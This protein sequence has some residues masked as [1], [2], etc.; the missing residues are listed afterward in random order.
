[1][2]TVL[3]VDD[4]SAIRMAIR[5]VVESLGF[6]VAEAADGQRALDYIKAHGTPDAIL[7]DI[8][9]PVM[10]GLTCLK[11]LR[12]DRTLDQARVVICTTHN[13]VEKIQE[14]LASGAN[15]YIMKPFDMEII[16]AKLEMVDLM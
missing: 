9:M 6:T 16:K 13:S 12:Q 5:R 11:A 3:V 2:K 8:N 4:S 7:L 15:E 14:A 1:M 10:D